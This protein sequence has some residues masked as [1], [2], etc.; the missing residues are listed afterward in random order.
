MN[1]SARTLTSHSARCSNGSRART[2]A[3][4]YQA[5]DPVIRC[6][7]TRPSEPSGDHAANSHSSVTPGP[8]GSSSVGAAPRSGELGTI[9]HTRSVPE[10]TVR[11]LSLAW[12]REL[13]REV[14]E[15]EP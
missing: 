11:Y 2:N 15:S 3:D 7:E 14:S 1:G 8:C 6:P 10:T 4:Q 12:L 9:G 13:T 5:R